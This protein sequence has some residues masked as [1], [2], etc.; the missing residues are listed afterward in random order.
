[1][2]CHVVPMT[3]SPEVKLDCCSGV[4]RPVLADQGLLLFEQ[5]DRGVELLLIQFIHILDAQIWLCG[6]EVQR[7]L[8]AM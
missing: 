6:L 3:E 7:R 4:I 5:A 8:S 2:T 1:M